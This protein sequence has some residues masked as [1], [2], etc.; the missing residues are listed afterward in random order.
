MLIITVLLLLWAIHKWIY[1]KLTV[2]AVF[3]YYTESGLELPDNDIIQKYRIK[4][5]TKSLKQ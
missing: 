1:Y 3:L 4:V 5:A 2:M